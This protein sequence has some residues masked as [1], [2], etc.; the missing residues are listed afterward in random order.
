MAKFALEHVTKT[1]GDTVAVE[2]LSLEV[3][4][5]ELL[6]LLGHSCCGKTTTLR[7][8]AKL[9]VPTEIRSGHA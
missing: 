9:E 6:L 4:D 1:F 3:V 2:D 7:M 8:I 5:E